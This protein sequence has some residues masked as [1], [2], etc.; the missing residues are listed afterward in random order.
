MSRSTSP[1]SWRP[2]GRRWAPPGGPFP[3]ERGEREACGGSLPLCVNALSAHLEV[4]QGAVSQ[5]H[6]IMR[7]AGL[8]IDEKR[9]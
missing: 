8:G 4:T 9:G 7:E 5:H 6:R 2:S 1:R 3:G